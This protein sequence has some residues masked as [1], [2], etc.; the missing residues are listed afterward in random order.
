MRFGGRYEDMREAHQAIRDILHLYWERTDYNGIVGDHD[1]GT[2]RPW[3]FVDRSLDD[4]YGGRE[5]EDLLRQGA[6]VALISEMLG[7]WEHGS[8]SWLEI[9]RSAVEQG[10]SI[11]FPLRVMRSSP[12]C[13]ATTR[14]FRTSVRCMRNTCSRRSPGGRRLGHFLTDAARATTDS[15]ACCDTAGPRMVG[16]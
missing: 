10:A 2:F 15:A 16:S 8:G 4:G 12:A 3:H 5:V 6:A 13:A 9:Y 11:L 14:S 7:L 1:T